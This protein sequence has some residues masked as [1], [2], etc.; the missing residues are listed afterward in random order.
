MR[1]RTGDRLALIAADVHDAHFD[2][3]AIVWD[4]GARRLTVPIAQEALQLSQAFG[5]LPG[6]RLVSRRLLSDVFRVPMID[7]TLV[8]EHVV[9]VERV[10]GWG[11]LGMLYD[12]TYDAGRGVV[13]LESVG[14]LIARVERLDVTLEISGEIAFHL[15]RRRGAVLGWEA[16]E[17]EREPPAGP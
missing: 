4:R 1:A 17:I 2:P 14:R 5:E 13:E 6:P 15:R 10:E 11:E 7:G 16:D 9:D 3:D 12:V 8:V